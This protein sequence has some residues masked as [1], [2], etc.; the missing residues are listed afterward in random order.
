MIGTKVRVREHERLAEHQSRVGEVV[1]YYSG[2]DYVDGYVALEVRF[3][4]GECRL[5]WVGDLEEIS[6]PP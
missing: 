5:F 4:D 1:G 2:D 6:S 3:S